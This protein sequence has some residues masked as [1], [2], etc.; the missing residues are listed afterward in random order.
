[1]L[2][3]TGVR[4]TLNLPLKIAKTFTIWTD[5]IRPCCC[6]GPKNSLQGKSPRKFRW[7]RIP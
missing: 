7:V 6:L 3:Y 4:R 2:S 5:W 1:L